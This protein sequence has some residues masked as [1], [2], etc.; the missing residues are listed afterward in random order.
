MRSGCI[1]SRTPPLNNNGWCPTNKQAFASGLQVVVAARAYDPPSLWRELRGP[2]GTPSSDF[3][4]GGGRTLGRR[5]RHKAFVFVVLDP[6]NG[7]RAPKSLSQR[8]GLCAN[9]AAPGS[10]AQA[11]EAPRKKSR[12]RA[13][14]GL[15]AEAARHRYPR[16]PG[17]PDRTPGRQAALWRI[18]PAAPGDA[19]AGLCP[20][21]AA[22]NSPGL[23]ASRAGHG[24]KSP[25]GSPPAVGPYRRSCGAC[26]RGLGMRQAPMRPR[27]EDQFPERFCMLGMHS[28]FE[29]GIN[30]W[31]A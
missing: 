5:G 16:S 14:P 17:A 11:C 12:S 15:G 3:Q 10:P 27:S 30:A 20:G 21:A 22:G 28:P 29:R 25:A 2:L 8:C 9:S 24:C 18:D 23:A 7:S 6:A 1:N 13:W 19:Q 26:F 4:A 31:R